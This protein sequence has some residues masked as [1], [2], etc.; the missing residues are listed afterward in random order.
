MCLTLCPNDDHFPNVSN[1]YGAGPHQPG[2]EYLLVAARSIAFSECQWRSLLRYMFPYKSV[3]FNLSMLAIEIDI[4]SKQQ[5]FLPP[6]FLERQPQFGSERGLRDSLIS[7]PGASVFLV[8][9]GEDNS[10]CKAHIG[11]EKGVL[12]QELDWREYE[13]EL[14]K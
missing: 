7:M 6:R 14:R 12:L 4:N 8:L 3:D 10:W 5:K 11:L 13:V 2:L 1:P 9:T